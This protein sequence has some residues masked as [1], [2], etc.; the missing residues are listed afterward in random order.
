MKLERAYKESST[1]EEA[2]AAHG[3]TLER[4]R[5]IVREAE[6]RLRRI[7]KEEHRPAVLLMELVE[8]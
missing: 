1:F 5:Q 4:A 8:N 6:V 2:A 3:L 7:F